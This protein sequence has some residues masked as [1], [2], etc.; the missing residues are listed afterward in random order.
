M[1]R[2]PTGGG[3]APSPFVGSQGMFLSA[4]SENK[5]LARTFLL[6]FVTTPETMRALYD[7]DPRN[8]ACRAVFDQLADNLVAQTF[9]LSAADGVPMLNIPEMGAVW[10]PLGNA[11]LLVRNGESEAAEAMEAAAQGV[12]EAVEG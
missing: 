10:G 11:L 3:Q 5:A 12:R 6:G 2:L 8:P 7:A 9:A 4:F 1:A